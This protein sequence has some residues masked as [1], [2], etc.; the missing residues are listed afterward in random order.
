LRT[1]DSG[2]VWKIR[3]YIH[4][5]KRHFKKSLR[6]KDLDVAKTKGR[7][8]YYSMM[9]KIDF[10]QRLFT[11]TSSELGKRYLDMQ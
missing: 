11:I 6:T 9:G 7:K 2:E 1:K 3:C 10:G 8:L 5:E 4:S